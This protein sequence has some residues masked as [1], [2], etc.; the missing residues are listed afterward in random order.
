MV[1]AALRQRILETYE[2]DTNELDDVIEEVAVRPRPGSSHANAETKPNDPAWRLAQRIGAEQS[3]DGRLLVQVLRQGEVPLF[4]ALFGVL[5]GIHPPRLQQVL[6]QSGGRGLAAACKALEIDKASFAP[7]F[8]LSRK[9]GRAHDAVDPTS[10]HRIVRFF[11]ELPVASA[12]EALRHWQRDPDYLAAIDTVVEET[13][14]VGPS[15]QA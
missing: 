3:I 13:S 4:E 1:S 12:R 7:I 14:H 5:S 15:K 11:D 2:I 10:L 9:G 8:L 6:Y